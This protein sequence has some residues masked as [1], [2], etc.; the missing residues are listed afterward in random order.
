[1]LS[2]LFSVIGVA[3]LA[4]VMAPSNADALSGS[5]WKAGRIIDDL[6]FTNSSSM[7]VEDIQR[8][9]NAKSTV[10]DT[11]GSKNVTYRYPFGS[12]PS[13]TTSRAV[14][15]DRKNNPKPTGQQIF[16]CLKDYY[17]V[18]KTQ[19][20]PGIPASNY[21]YADPH[22]NRPSGSKSAAEL[23]WDAAQAYKISPKV[24]LITLQKEQ[25][26]VTDDWPLAA[27]YLYATGAQCP[28]GP[29]GAECSTNYAG[30]SL[31]AREGARLLR[32][33]LDNMEKS[34]WPYKKPFMTNRIAFQVATQAGCGDS[35]VYIES[36]STAALYTYT[37]Y[38]PNKAALDNLYGTGDSCSAY[39]NRNF[40][41]MYNDWFGSTRL[42]GVRPAYDSSYAKAP[43]SAPTLSSTQIARLYNPDT[44]DYLW[45]NSGPEACSARKMGYIWD[46]IV[47]S[48]AS[49][50]ST[51]ATPVFRLSGF[52]RHIYT[53]ST[54][55]KNRYI[56]QGYSDEGVAFHAYVD[57]TTT[58]E[59]RSE[60]YCLV[61]DSQ[62]IYTSSMGER[63]GLQQQGFN[64][65]G[66][67]FLLPNIN[68]REEASRY[69]NSV[70]SR[71]YSASAIEKKVLPSYGYQK[72]NLDFKVD[73]M[74]GQQN[75]PVYRLR[76]PYGRYFYT[77][78]RIERDQAVINHSYFSEGIAFYTPGNS[79]LG[80]VTIYRLM[81]P[82]SAVRLYT[83]SSIER[84]LAVRN[85]G[86]RSEGTAWHG[87]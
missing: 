57:S 81:D 85:Y 74:P 4:I 58:S 25:S 46:G 48:S 47:F 44:R 41:R 86:F 34:W 79:T 53:S 49:P 75:S 71:I 82:N 64:Y 76:D 80:P 30:F 35:S 22:N 36:K 50:T 38:Q 32:Y 19:V 77:P 8:F 26:L 67:A 5:D 20:G 84:D 72:E 66:V 7:S 61:K 28:D 70:H 16:T 69:V 18:P 37:P 10:C 29:N 12:G 27:Q 14:Y 39:G 62:V 17:E 52:E 55:V 56:S 31:Q 63:V 65:L 2:K 11:Y 13:V 59:P 15:A 40:W 87:Y 9:L 60:V 51:G 6:I 33:Y 73:S 83:T 42:A 23:I 3:A 45:T 78:S 21:G 68:T 54:D 1:M 43:C 24:L